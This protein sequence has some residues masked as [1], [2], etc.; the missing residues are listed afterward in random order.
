M[1]AVFFLAVLVA[2]VVATALVAAP[3]RRGSPRTWLAV[4][5]VVP[6]LSLGLY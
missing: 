5:A 6:V 3:L 1:A 4:M 2:A